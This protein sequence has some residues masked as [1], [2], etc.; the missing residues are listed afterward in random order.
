MS[1]PA[2][3]VVIPTYDNASGL[4]RCLAALERQSIGPERFDV[5]VVDDGSPA[6]TGALLRAFR[7]RTRLRLTCLRAEHGGPGAARNLGL[8]RARGGL[9]AFTD[10]DCIPS[11]TWLRDYLALAPFPAGVAGIGGAV[12]FTPE[13][14]T[15]RL[16]HA[17]GHT[18]NPRL[19]SGDAAFLVTA[20]AL[21]AK[22]ELLDV[23]GFD[24]RY[25]LA[26][27]EDSDLAYRIVARGGRLQT[28]GG[29]LVWHEARSL[30]QLLHT[31]LRYGA[32]TRCQA[33]IGVHPWMDWNL[34]RI[35][36]L[37]R[38]RHQSLRAAGH[39]EPERSAF[40]AVEGLCHLS[41]GLGWHSRRLRAVHRERRVRLAAPTPRP[42]R[43]GRSPVFSIVLL[44]ASPAQ[45]AEAR[46]RLAALP[47]VA[48]FEVLPVPG[49]PSCARARNEA[50]GRARGRYVLTLDG[51]AHLA[52][53]SLERALFIL[54]R[55]PRIG[56]VTGPVRFREERAEDRSGP[57]L[58][59]PGEPDD[60][61][62]IGAGAVFRRSLWAELGGY[63]EGCDD[64]DR[65]LWRRLVSA[66]A[67]IQSVAEVFYTY[68]YPPG[69][70][71]PRPATLR[72]RLGRK[73][74][75]RGAG[76]SVPSL[77]MRWG[78]RAY[79]WLARRL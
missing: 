14:W 49:D 6:A 50:L 13:T 17:L 52:P 62:A 70:A 37:M 40:V 21:F 51:D 77:P 12:R 61:L 18:Q 43:A 22:E 60:P 29:A 58:C 75:G 56:V 19:A 15:A 3:S 16:C 39:P 32:G 66:G 65:D 31:Y 45:R 4:R 34:S 8:R 67:R 73:L 33:E 38:E 30:P 48:T 28:T 78:N 42:A 71:T 54:E 47:G 57:P 25:A 27:G 36:N 24:E 63:D 2:L 76:D 44:F 53:Y 10:D 35:R 7:A 23:G 72:E 55:D 9:V 74:V 41:F 11:P 5:V 59:G 46:R 64:P 20:N 68:P 69:R 1:E 26:G 79:R